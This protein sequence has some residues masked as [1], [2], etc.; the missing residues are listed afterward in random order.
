[1]PRLPNIRR[2]ARFAKTLCLLVAVLASCHPQTSDTD[3]SVTPPSE[4]QR[5]PVSAL[6]DD[7]LLAT[8]TVAAVPG[9]NTWCRDGADRPC[10]VVDE[11]QTLQAS[12][13]AVADPITDR[14][15][16]KVWTKDESGEYV[17]FMN[18]VESSRGWIGMHYQDPW[19]FHIDEREW[20]PDPAVVLWR[21][22]RGEVTRSQWATTQSEDSSAIYLT[23]GSDSRGDWQDFRGF[24][25]QIW[26]AETLVL[27]VTMPNGDES[28]TIFDLAGFF[29]TPLSSAGGN[30]ESC[31]VL[32]APYHTYDDIE[33]DP[34][35]LGV[36][37][38]GN[39]HS[40]ALLPDGTI[41]CWGS[42]TD[43]PEE[44][45]VGVF[46]GGSL[47]CGLRSGG[48]VEC[49]GG[50][51]DQLD[52]PEGMF[53]SLSVG[54]G[55]VCGLLDGGTVSCWGDDRIRGDSNTS[56]IDAP[57]G[58]FLTVASAWGYSC[59]LRSDHSVQ[60]WGNTGW[61]LDEPP[62]GRFAALSVGAVHACALRTNGTAACWGSN[63]GGQINSP[64]VQF[65]AIA[66][67]GGH[68]S[69][70]GAFGHS[71]GIRVDGTVECW[72]GVGES[73]PT[74]RLAAISSGPFHVCGQT[75]E[76]EVICWGS[77]SH[78]Q[79]T[80]PDAQFVAIST[81]S[82]TCGLQANGEI[83]CWTGSGWGSYPD[84]RF[85]AVSDGGAP[86]W[87]YMPLICGLDSDG[88][89]VCNGG[90][91][92]RQATP[93][94][95][96]FVSVDTGI[97]HACALNKSGE[98]RCWESGIYAQTWSPSGTFASVSAGGWHTCGLRPD[99]TVECWGGQLYEH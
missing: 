84:R 16:S 52:P 31:G 79:T 29:S 39:S 26:G 72:G 80:R 46:A 83:T 96:T 7:P 6:A 14:I 44:V 78:G 49:W 23:P 30:L 61:R 15:T 33:I 95:G 41:Q 51:S 59:G 1:M 32:S 24:V 40:C 56:A 55:H 17:L 70:G 48:T 8:T 38:A 77:N 53:T 43:T 73:P 25:D 3:S 4:P 60:C 87:P 45:F 62:D 74:E 82:G 97:E 35:P 21:V 92:H 67:G 13:S 9:V 27:R 88:T 99:G 98:A 42:E 54:G 75:T 58:D 10:W 85:V 63:D 20:V 68:D 91:Q 89:I 64:P 76:G 2:N 37:A 19:Y 90:N 12:W 36:V 69:E 94:K 66:V 34:S 93:P 65:T 22:D 47:S 5:E 50:N 11:G 28:T 81:G 86:G 71:C 57:G 18:C